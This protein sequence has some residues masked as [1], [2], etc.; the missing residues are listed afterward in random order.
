MK[1]LVTGAN[2]FVGNAMVKQLLADK[3][4]VMGI[5]RS[6][7][8]I[9]PDGV[10]RFLISDISAKTNW[11]NILEGVNVVIHTAARVHVMD[12]S[13]ADPLLEFRK[14]NV[15]GTLNIARQAADAGVKRFIFISS[16]KVNGEMTEAGQT[17]KANDS[18]IPTDPYGLSKYEAEK[19]L[20]TIAEE[21]GMEVVIIRPPLIYGPGVKAN[22]SAMMKWINRG[23][24]LP[25]GAIHNQRSLVAL[26]NLVDF[27]ALC[28]DREKSHKAAN[29]VFLIS[30]GEDVSTTTLLRKVANAF[31]KKPRLI[32]VPV[33]LMI[34]AAKLIG[35][36]DIANR[37]FGSLQV[38]SSKARDLLGWQPVVTMDEQLAKMVE[39]GGKRCE[40]SD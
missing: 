5:V 30:D 21:T 7:A 27:I 35:K 14:V 37:L 17:F 11:D 38:D 4:E 8:S 40:L 13:V 1:I 34:F 2:G 12:D 36:G 33:W 28:A 32:P 10:G 20:L 15:D 39:V 19:G 29:E 31:G 18:H 6:T 25:F 9:L 24:P 3:H 22:F 23:V 16:I 26:D